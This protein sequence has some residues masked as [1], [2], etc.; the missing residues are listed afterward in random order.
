MYDELISDGRHLVTL[1]GEHLPDGAALSQVQT[2]ATAAS[3]W[4]TA[5]WSCDGSDVWGTVQDVRRG[6]LCGQVIVST[7]TPG[8]DTPAS[9]VVRAAD[10]V[11]G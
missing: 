10:L 6:D 4:L 5:F 2:N 11:R 9:V 7:W 1:Y 3:Y 8:S